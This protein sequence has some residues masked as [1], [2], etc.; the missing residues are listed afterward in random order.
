VISHDG[1]CKLTRTYII[2]DAS[3]N[4]AT[5][6]Q[7]FTVDDT[8]APVINSV[9]DI[10]SAPND[11]SCGANLYIAAPTSIT[12][13]CSLVN[14]GANYQY[15]IAGIP[16]SGHGSFTALFP[17]GITAITWTVTDVCGHVSAPII[18]TVK[19]GINLTSISYD[20]GSTETAS[21][22][23]IQ[24]MQTSTHEYF[25]DN[26]SPEI[27]YSYTWELFE[28]DG[29]TAVSSSLYTKNNVN[30]AHIKISYNTI[31]TGN[32]IISV[33]KTRDGSTCQ[34]QMTLPI[35]V[36][37]NSSFDVIL[38]NLGNQ[39]Q[40]P[41]EGLTTISWNVTF[42][43]VITEPFMFS[44]SI[45]LGG[46]VV[47]TGNVLNITYAGGIPTPGLSAGV[48]AGKSANSPVVVLNYSLY[49]VS[50]NDL[51]RTVE[52]EISATDIYQVSEPNTTNNK[53]DLKINQVP[54]INFE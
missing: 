51:A 16:H 22:S 5:C 33:K 26:K 21:G 31:S 42:P 14:E 43:S 36:Q 13:N 30:A 34:K 27:G 15:T 19:V 2:K 45:K 12:E 32:Y 48:Q 8:K 49:G 50:G 18:Q 40:A 6:T 37:S 11:N 9:V 52:I 39:C 35:K 25:V 47:A 17:E 53:D 29:V 10:Q 20:N 38:D 23:G 24:P 4:P 28:A 1:E 44:Y 54:V 41:S 3:G 7:I 46:I